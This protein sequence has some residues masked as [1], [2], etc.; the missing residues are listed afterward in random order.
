ML[1]DIFPLIGDELRNWLR[2]AGQGLFT[3]GL[4]GQDALNMLRYFGG[5]IR[6]SDF[7]AI[8]RDVL[9][10][11]SSQQ[12]LV[13]DMQG[14]DVNALIPAAWHSDLVQPGQRRDFLYYVKVT[15]TDIDTG[16]PRE[17]Y[18]GYSSDRQL[19]FGQLEEHASEDAVRSEDTYR[20]TDVTVEIVSAYAKPGRW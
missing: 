8:R 11:Q 4:T 7:Y 19:S 5:Q 17:Q 1:P 16:L 20:M 9:R 13:G 3:T 12:T 14:Y 18:Y 10:D 6:T 15:G 2:T